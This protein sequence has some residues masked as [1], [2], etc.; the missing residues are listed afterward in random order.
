MIV[1]YNW[2]LLSEENGSRFTKTDDDDDDVNIQ[3][4]SL[5]LWALILYH[6]TVNIVVIS[7]AYMNMNGA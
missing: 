1:C 5:K 3:I 4:C 6:I 7:E 2:L